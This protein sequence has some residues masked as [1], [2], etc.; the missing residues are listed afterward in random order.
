MKQL[1]L[2]IIA[3]GLLT[4][5]LSAQQTNRDTTLDEV[6]LHE[7]V[8]SASRGA[9]AKTAIA[10]QVRVI[11]S[12]EIERTNPPTTAELLQS[13]GQVFVQKSQQGGGSPVLRGFEASRVLLVIDGV[14]MNNAIYR[15]G[16]LQNVIT[17]DNA[18][19]DRAEILFGPASTL[20]GTDALG[21]AICFYTKNPE[22]STEKGKLK[23][24]IH[25]F[26]RYATV[27]NEKT[28]H[29]DFNVGS[30]KMASFTS[31]T[32]SDFDD[33]RM[34]KKAGFA[35]IFGLRPYYVERI[36]GKDSLLPN[37]NPYLQKFS[38]YHQYDVLQKVVYQPA[39]WVKHTV[40]VQFSNSS[41]IPR[42]DRLT[43]PKGSGL[44]S[45]EWYYGPQKRILAAYH[46]NLKKIVGFDEMDITGSWQ[47]IA[48]SR[49]NRNFGEI[50]RTERSEKVKVY[51][52]VAQ[53]VKHFHQHTIRTGIDGQFN[54]VAS[55]ARRINVN[56][57][58]IST[59]STRY[60]DGGS[61]LFTLAAF[62]SHTWSVGNRWIFSEGA[63]AGFSNLHGR[64]IS[65][66]YF[67][68]LAGEVSQKT[69][70]LAGNLGAV[71]LGP[72]NT[73][74]AINAST[75]FRVPNIDDMGKV[76]DS[77]PG[78]V[79]V[80]N[81]ALK[82]EKT[83]NME[84]NVSKNIAG[85]LLWENVCWATTLR[86]AVVPG[87]FQVNGNDSI[88]FDGVK[89]EV[90]ALQNQRTATLLG[91]TT[92]LQADISP[93]LAAYASL[94]YTR[95]RI[96]ELKTPLDHIPPLFGRAGAR[97][98]ARNAN[99]EVYSLFNGKKKREAYNLEGEDNWQYAPE[100]GMPAWI[101]L[102]FRLGYSLSNHLNLQVGVEN[103]LDVQY[104]HF[105]SGINAPGRNLWLT[106]RFKW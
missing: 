31:L 10:Q 46:L 101:T 52:L 91:F 90:L 86:D 51:G 83:Y 7:T 18:A 39:E 33:L 102:N 28:G 2:T 22:Q 95:G 4:S 34:G 26:S 21:G 40:N 54:E 98:H 16:H 68:F 103:L 63:R 6:P 19:L 64:F 93:T 71:F 62:G 104:R 88:D 72:K 32:F 11:K 48:E 55:S 47:D 36:N 56:S 14:R 89:S 85:K 1:I 38:G 69:P 77:Q 79:V 53:A 78:R 106:I 92:S 87:R 13:T 65:T 37:P 82:S 76:F 43:D 70:T 73:R 67:S 74:I 59:Q 97:W 84:L 15:S 99:L 45:A 25:A 29:L 96:N 5:G 60:P 35:P 8:I 94:S 81:P 50:N 44:N 80:P 75:G 3:Y 24:S 27:N 58:E 17:L 57:G 30:V 23:T 12:A 49:V 61:T 41:N 105:A 20:Y 100:D 66:E 9:Q 42:Y